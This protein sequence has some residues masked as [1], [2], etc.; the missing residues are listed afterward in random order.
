LIDSIDLVLR[1]IDQLVHGL[2]D[3]TEE[4]VNIGEDI[5]V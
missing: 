5:V 4:D 3:L 1:Q 2:Y